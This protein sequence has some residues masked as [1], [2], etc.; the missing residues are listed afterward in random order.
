M[1]ASE[2][3]S[4]ISQCSSELSKGDLMK[5]F[6]GSYIDRKP[7]AALLDEKRDDAASGVFM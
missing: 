1:N 6:G 4:T 3:A 2:S 5:R 7:N